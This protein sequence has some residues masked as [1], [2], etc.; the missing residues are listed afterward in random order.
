MKQKNYTYISWALYTS[1]LII[2]FIQLGSAME[3]DPSNVSGYRLFP[4]F[5]LLA[6]LVMAGHY[7]AGA[8]RLKNSNLTKP[9]NYFKITNTTVLVSLLAHPVI[10]AVEQAKSGAGIPPESFIS[11]VGEG[12]KIAVMLGSLSLALFLSYEVFSRIKDK[13]T[14]KKNWIFVSLSQSLA[15]TLIWV[16]ALRLGNS[17]G[18]GWVKLL[19][20]F[21]G[22]ALLPCFYII[23]R[24]EF[25]TKNS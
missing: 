17:V 25:E 5:G 12:L 20:L 21:M 4:F 2:T 9:K 23:H 8:L 18:D 10:L 14:V 7:Y 11:Y 13:P 16:H 6:W 24:Y 1:A 19:W 3:W 15:M 22:L